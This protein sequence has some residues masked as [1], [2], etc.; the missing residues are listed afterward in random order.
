MELFERVFEIQAGATRRMTN[1]EKPIRVV[2][3]QSLFEM[4]RGEL[5]GDAVQE[6]RPSSPRS[7]RR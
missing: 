2:S 6:E 4:P 7:L 1:D 3:F 5:R